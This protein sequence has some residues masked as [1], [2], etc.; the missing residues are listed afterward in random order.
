MENL[1]QTLITLAKLYPNDTVFGEEVR[2]IVW[3]LRKVQKNTEI[4]EWD[5]FTATQEY[6]MDQIRKKYKNKQINE[7]N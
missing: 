3:Q 1:E 2:K 4:K 5:S 6:E 7:N